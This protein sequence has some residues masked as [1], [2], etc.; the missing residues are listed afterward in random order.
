MVKLL[1]L[2]MLIPLAM[3][4]QG[5]VGRLFYQ[6]DKKSYGTPASYSLPYEE[7]T[8]SS[9]DGTRLSGWFVPAVGTP[10][11]TVIHFHGNAQNMSAH[12]GFVNWL[13]AEGFNLFVFDYRGY[14]KS[15]GG[16]DR[17]GVYEDSVA[18]L[19]YVAARK[20][21]D[22][23]RLLILGQ[24]LGGANAIAAAG[25]NRFSGIRAVAIESAFSS[26][27]GIVRDKI[28]EIPLLSFLKWPLSFL[29]I[30]NSLSPEAVVAKIAPV[31][32]LLIYG[33]ADP[34]VPYHHGTGLYARAKEP[35]ELWTIEGGGHTEAFA[36]SGSPYRAKLVRFF[37][38]ALAKSHSTEQR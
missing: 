25:G 19:S 26:Y 9:K 7:V 17:Q 20:G 2:V 29:L 21:I 36:E 11:G 24:S 35:K 6:P 1:L 18:A 12:F 30:G 31:P 13:P 10:R 3:L 4:C 16:P 5:C 38:E 33:T 22:H 15:G 8:F 28:G 32:L 14:G 23:N 37:N 27:R 34:V